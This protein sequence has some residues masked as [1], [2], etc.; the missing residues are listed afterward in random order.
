MNGK[1]GLNDLVII[2]K[3][4][5]LAKSRNLRIPFVFSIFGLPFSHRHNVAAPKGGS[6]QCCQHPV[7]LSEKSLD[8]NTE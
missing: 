5:V 6:L 1:D 7:V 2:L 4:L 8:P 3:R